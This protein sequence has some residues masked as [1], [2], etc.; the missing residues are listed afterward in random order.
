METGGV[1]DFTWIPELIDNKI[2]F[3]TAQCDSLLIIYEFDPKN[4]V[5]PPSG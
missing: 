2:Y 5:A 3:M 4:S 1:L